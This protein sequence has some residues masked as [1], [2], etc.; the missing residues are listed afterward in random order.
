MEVN[1]RND[2]RLL[3]VIGDP[4]GH[5]LSPLLHNTMA[6]ELGENALYLACNIRREALPDWLAAVRTVPFLGFNATMPHKLD[7][8]Q[9]CDRLTPE[10]TYFGAVNTVR[11]DGGVLTGHNTDGDGFA[12]ALRERG[13]Q[14]AGATVAILGAGGAAGAI[15]RK[16]A[17]DG[18]A[19]VHVYN[20][21]LQ[22]AEALCAAHPVIHAHPLTEPLLPTTQIL[23]N[24][25]PVQAGSQ[26]GALAPL[27][28][29]CAVFDIL[30]APPKTELLLAAEARG[31]RI[32]NGLGML[33]YQAILAF[34]FFTGRKFDCAE[35][36]KCL[37]RAVEKQ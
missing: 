5:S 15:A 27:S 32:G 33:I 4:V 2:T 22:N 12:L 8:L 11:N 31:M 35:M 29:E 30:Y 6:R 9:L 16:A 20:R 36:A 18:A 23:I 26:A 1:Y 25:L 37:Y 24:T 21:T 3:A 34:S 14:F 13:L 7:L 19:A 28:R 10:A 17:L